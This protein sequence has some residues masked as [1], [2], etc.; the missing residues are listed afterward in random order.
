ARNLRFKRSAFA[1]QRPKYRSRPDPSIDLEDRIYTVDT[2][3]EGSADL[4]AEL[5]E[6]VAAVVRPGGRLGVV[7]HARDRQ[8]GVAEPFQGLVVEV[9]V[10]EFDVGREG[11]RVDCK[12]VVLGRDLDLP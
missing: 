11:A 10:A 9:D 5:G 1:L 4:L 6:E 12:A 8:S 7:L 3:D 2:W